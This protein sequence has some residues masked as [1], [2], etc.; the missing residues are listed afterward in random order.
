MVIPDLQNL[1]G[2]IQ[3]QNSPIW[4]IGEYVHYFAFRPQAL[5]FH[6]FANPAP[7][8]QEKCS[9]AHL[10]LLI[11]FIA[12]KNGQA[13]YKPRTCIMEEFELVYNLIEVSQL[14]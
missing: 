1:V 2:L 13:K 12:K 8:D 11:F 10:L 5:T 9:N 7:F 6:A 3:N 14:D 4:L